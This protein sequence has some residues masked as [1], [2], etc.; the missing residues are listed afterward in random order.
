MKGLDI[1]SYQG[2]INFDAIKSA[3]IEFL[4]IRAGFTGWGTGVN[5]NKDKYFEEFYN[6]SKSHNIP[7]G[8]YWYSCA[9]TKE[10]GIAEAK[11]MYDNCLKGKQFEYPIYIDVEDTHHQVGNKRGV[12]DAIIGFCE[13]LENLGYYVGIYASDISGFKDKMYINELNQYDKWVARYE[14]KPTY[15]INYGMWQSS[16]SGKINGYNGNLDTDVAFKNYCEIIKNAGLNG[17]SKENSVNLLDKYSDEELAAMVWQGKFGN[18]EERKQKLGNRYDGVQNLVN[19]GVGKDNTQP[20]T[21]QENKADI[22]EMVRKTIRGDYGTGQ[23]RKNVLGK[24]Y[25]EVQHQVELNLR[26]GRTRWDNIKL[27]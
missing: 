13:Y 17:Y 10:K 7:V 8:A 26:D 22:L 15:V 18:G 1:S 12:T 6:K 25:D 4:I 24:Y 16:S 11:F 21:S 9:N 23:S 19:Q 14:S 27:Y 20:S 5:Y 3:G 2:G